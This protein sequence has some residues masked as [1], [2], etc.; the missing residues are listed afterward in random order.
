MNKNLNDFT[1]A[2]G[3][4]TESVETLLSLDPEDESY[5]IWERDYRDTIERVS[6]TKDSLSLCEQ[7]I[8]AKPLKI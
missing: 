3:I 8:E 1:R 4:L 6:G 5:R 7:R 2:E